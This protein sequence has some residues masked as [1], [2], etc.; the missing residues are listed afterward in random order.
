[1][2]FDN[3]KLVFIIAYTWVRI[4]DWLI[5][6]VVSVLKME[7]FYKQTGKQNMFCLYVLSYRV[8]CPVT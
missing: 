4:R 3:L 5:F 7:E 6:V 2:K 8:I 1:M